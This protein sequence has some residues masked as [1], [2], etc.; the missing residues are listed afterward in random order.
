M[1]G[2]PATLLQTGHDFANSVK[3]FCS[4]A[5]G[6]DLHMVHFAGKATVHAPSQPAESVVGVIH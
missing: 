4:A 6:T 1:T 2:A 5:L 3:R